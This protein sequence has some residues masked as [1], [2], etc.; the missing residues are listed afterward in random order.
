MLFLLFLEAKQSV[1]VIEAND[2]IKSV[3]VI[4]VTEVFRTS[5]ILKI[6]DIKARM[7]SYFDILKKK[8]FGI[9]SWNFSEILHSLR[10]ETVEDR[11]VTFNQIKG[12]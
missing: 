4:E 8:A 7:L 1:E 3:E 12:S 9:N 6:N 11:D 2:V 5:R 10:T